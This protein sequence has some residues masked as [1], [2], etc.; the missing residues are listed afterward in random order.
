[1]KAEKSC[2]DT[3]TAN[4]ADRYGCNGDGMCHLPLRRVFCVKAVRTCVRVLDFLVRVP[5][6]GRVALSAP[7]L[8][9]VWH[10]RDEHVKKE[11]CHVVLV[12]VGSLQR[13]SVFV[14]D[15]PA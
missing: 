9:V 13:G 5:L 11:L 15:E 4:R 1:M 2:D 10:V 12:S 7:A 8:T 14:H 3:Q 6:E